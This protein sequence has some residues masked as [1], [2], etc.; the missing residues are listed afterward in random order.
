MELVRG[1]H[2]WN[3]AM[4]CDNGQLKW[5]IAKEHLIGGITASN[6]PRSY[7]NPEIPSLT[8]AWFKQDLLKSLVP[9]PTPSFW[10][11]EKL[12]PAAARTTT[13][14]PREVEVAIIGAGYAGASIAYHLLCKN[15]NTRQPSTV[16]LEAREACSGA[17][18]RNGGHLKPDPFSKAADILDSHGTEAASQVAEFER[19]NF[20]EIAKL[21]TEDDVQCDFVKGCAFEVYLQ[22]EDFSAASRRLDKA[23]RANIKTAHDA[24]AIPGGI[25][26]TISGIRGAA[27]LI[28]YAAARLWPYKLVMY[29]LS[30]AIRC[31]A[32]LQTNAVVHE[33]SK[34][35]DD[36]DRWELKTSRGTVKAKQV[37]YA[38]NA[39]TASLVPE[40]RNLLVPVRGVC[41]RIVLPEM[42]S[43]KTLKQSY[44]IRFNDWEHDYLIPMPD[45]SII[46]GG[47]RRNYYQQLQS[48]YDNFDDAH[49]IE[50]AESHFDGYMQRLFRDWEHSG[51]YTDSAFLSAKAVAA[52]I[53][54]KSTMQEMDI[55][56]LF[57]TS[58][59]NTRSRKIREPK[60]QAV[61]AI[62]SA[63]MVLA[64]QLDLP[65]SLEAP[66]IDQELPST[67][68][69]VSTAHIQSVA[70]RKTRRIVPLGGIDAWSLRRG[71]I[72]STLR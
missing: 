49:V 61:R 16:I 38:T 45:G 35:R 18:G 62:L 15:H 14:C 22:E 30:E 17:S 54:R 70:S 53:A 21:I 52:L 25:A 67:Y 12:Q 66:E 23:K 50:F 40:L 59:S 48:W 55:P 56:I 2:L 5:N 6:G 42:E 20:D 10:S 1:V 34:S 26:E 13:G 43:L 47:A 28:T 41:C 46:L 4:E 19:R 65:D 11:S 63:K 60:G 72:V 58:G 32:N 3:R 36:A 68:F 9:N 8:S 71:S 31:G 51:A 33:V 27:G 69:A 24:L 57:R 7:V 29:L 44:S 39:F 37:V 64:L